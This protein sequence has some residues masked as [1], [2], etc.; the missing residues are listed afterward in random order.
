MTEGASVPNELEER[1]H[2][3]ETQLVRLGLR[4]EHVE[5]SVGEINVG[6][7]SLLERAA[8][9]GD[10]LSW[11]GIAGAVVTTCAVLMALG[12]L[13]S[14]GIAVSPVVQDHERRLTKLDDPDVGRVTALERRMTDA[15]SWAT[16][17]RPSN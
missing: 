11:R 14:W 1:V 2:K 3:S 5:Q 15:K 6:V 7:K 9:R 17:V 12:G 8:A 10:P 16:S 4:L 13:V